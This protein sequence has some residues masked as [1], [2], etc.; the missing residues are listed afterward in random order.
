[1]SIVFVPTNRRF[2]VVFLVFFLGVPSQSQQ[3]VPAAPGDCTVEEHKK[4]QD[5]VNKF[6]KNE[7]SKCTSDLS[8]KEIDERWHRAERCANARQ[9]INKKCFQS[10]DRG[11]KQAE[12]VFRSAA[13]N[14]KKI[15]KEK[16][17]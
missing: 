10:G 5:D 12:A 7:K 2:S 14:C 8:C 1:M 6:C 11:H 3:P 4:L 16:C 15:Y 9:R 17:E 13:S